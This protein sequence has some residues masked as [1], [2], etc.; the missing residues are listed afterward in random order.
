MTKKAIISGA[1]RGLGAAMAA[2]LT[3]AGWDVLKVSRSAGERVDLASPEALT[4]W[5]NSGALDQFLAQ[6]TDI[7]LIN[8]AGTVEPI[9]VSGTL[10]ASSVQSAIQLNITAP[11][12]LTDAVLAARP[13]GTPVRI[14]HISSGA[15]RH[16]LT[17]WAVYCA[18]KAAVD[19]HAKVLAAE[20]LDGVTVAAIAPG[21]VDT[22]MQSVIRDADFPDRDRFRD[23]KAN[24]NLTAPADAAAAILALADRDDFGAK[25]VADVREA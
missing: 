10:D 22:E 9:G 17:G 12:L 25:P 4:T 20:G 15:G 21:V 14:V 1:S 16:P 19:M 23:M 5:V 8:N 18:T 7:L 11:I 13:A 3:D 6:A 24:G 2:Q